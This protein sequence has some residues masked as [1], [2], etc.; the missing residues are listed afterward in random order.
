MAT[1]WIASRSLYSPDESPFKAPT[2]DELVVLLNRAKQLTE[3]I[4]TTTASTA[5]TPKEPSD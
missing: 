2:V 5:A 1:G 4:S 3:Y